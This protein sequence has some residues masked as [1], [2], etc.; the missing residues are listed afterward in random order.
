MR[1]EAGRKLHA[2][3]MEIGARIAKNLEP[4]MTQEQV[5][6]ELGISPTLVA[7]IERMALWKIQ[8]RIKQMGIT[9]ES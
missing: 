2:E 4:R 7:N 6:E 8:H 1:T 5:A 3:R 9:L